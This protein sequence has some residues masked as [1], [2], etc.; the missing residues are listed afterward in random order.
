MPRGIRQQHRGFSALKPQ[1]QMCRAS[2]AQSVKTAWGH[3]EPKLLVAAGLFESWGPGVSTMPGAPDTEGKGT[4]PFHNKAGVLEAVAAVW[5]PGQVQAWVS[6]SEVEGEVGKPVTMLTLQRFPLKVD[7]VRWII[8]P[9]LCV[10][11]QQAITEHRTIP[12]DRVMRSTCKLTST[13]LSVFQIGSSFS[14]S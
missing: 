8:F 12:R 5:T 2:K 14:L 10:Q 9:D 6:N 1:P 11:I 4:E 7:T 3:L 13:L